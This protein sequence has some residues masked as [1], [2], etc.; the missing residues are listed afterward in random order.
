M[1]FFKSL[2]L[3]GLVFG[4]A[5]AAHYRMMP[6]RII[7]AAPQNIQN[8]NEILVQGY[9]N[10]IDPS[11]GSFQYGYQQSNGASVS[12]KGYLNQAG[13]QVIEGSYSFV[14]AAG[15]PV[16]IQY[17]ADENGY[18][19]VGDSI[20]QPDPVIAKAVAYLKSLPPSKEDQQ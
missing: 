19:A 9:S 16:Q 6:R 13:K 4:I 1:A 11:T 10:E 3:F 17:V 8:P 5:S 18:Q 7:R 14:D 2:V 15:V 12:A 20:P